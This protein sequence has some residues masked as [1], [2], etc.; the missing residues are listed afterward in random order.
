MIWIRSPES[1]EDAAEVE[2]ESVPG[3]WFVPGLLEGYSAET[4]V[5]EFFEDRSRDLDGDDEA[6]VLTVFDVPATNIG[7]LYRSSVWGFTCEEVAFTGLRR[8]YVCVGRV[9]FWGHVIAVD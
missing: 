4:V 8:G 3:V 9:R 7:S 2:R 5:V 6:E 1:Q